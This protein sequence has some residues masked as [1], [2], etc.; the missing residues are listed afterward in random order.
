MESYTKI[1][2]LMQCCN[3]F[4]GLSRRYNQLIGLIHLMYKDIKSSF[5]Q[6]EEK[7]NPLEELLRNPPPGVSEEYIKHLQWQER[8][9]TCCPIFTLKLL[10]GKN[11]LSTF[12][13]IFKIM[14]L[15]LFL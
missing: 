15:T 9:R 13:Y 5:F 2:L 8:Q 7:I 6:E 1:G 10:C 4:S 12:L 3:D 14:T 11:Q